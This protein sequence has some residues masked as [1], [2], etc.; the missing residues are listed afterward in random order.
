MHLLE[1]CGGRRRAKPLDNQRVGFED[2][3]VTNNNAHPQLFDAVQLFLGSFVVL[4]ARISGSIEDA[5]IGQNCRCAYC[6]STPGGV[7]SSAR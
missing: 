7:H 5:S 3:R 1:P 2:S 4:V 6:G